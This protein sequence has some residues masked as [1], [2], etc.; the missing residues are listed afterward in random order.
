MQKASSASPTNLACLS[1][2]LNTATVGM[3]RRRAVTSTLQAISP[4]QENS[5]MGLKY[6]GGQVRKGL[7]RCRRDVGK[8]TANSSSKMQATACIVAGQQVLVKPLLRVV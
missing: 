6:G 4:L 3:P 2:S 5:R 1:A 8:E 7:T